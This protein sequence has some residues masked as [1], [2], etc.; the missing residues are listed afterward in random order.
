MQKLHLVGFTTDQNGLILSARR[1][2]RSGGYTLVLDDS[3]AQAVE[4]MRARQE[5]EAEAAGR[6]RSDRA[7]SRLPIGEIQTR[8]RRGRSLKD[9]AKDAGVEPEWVERFAAP[10]FAERAEV[11][12]RVQSLYYKRQRLGPSGLRVGDAVRRNLA[13][14]GVVMS[15]AEYNDAWKAVQRPDGRWMVTFGFQ[16]RGANRTLK[17]EVRPNGDIVASDQLTS[18]IAYVTPPK[19]STPRPRPVPASTEDA[20][21]KRAVVSTGF[22]PDPVVKAVSRP[23][24]ER[25]KAAAAMSKAAAKRAI[26]GERAANRKAREREQ[27]MLR[28]ERARAADA[29]RREREVAAKA[30]EAAAAARLVAAEQAEREKATAAI[31]AARQAERDAARRAARLKV[32]AESK[33][34]AAKK[35]AASKAGRANTAKAAA[36][37]RSERA[38]SRPAVAP[39]APRHAKPK[40]RPSADA[41]VDA[42]PP[43]RAAATTPAPER[44]PAPAPERR[45]APVPERRATPAPAPER[46]PAPARAATPAPAPRPA[47]RPAPRPRPTLAEAAAEVYG[48]EPRRAQFREG[49]A[50]QAT[51]ATPATSA[52][53]DNGVAPRRPPGARRTRPLRAT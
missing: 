48:N 49:A 38:S 16:H 4:E 3:L 41:R 52:N 53:P 28:L 35:T 51:Q 40:G 15:P 19:R 50:T 8:L 12:A 13:E 20:S 14:R 47:A 21:A 37:I 46:R 32:K 31:A 1:G 36:A 26:E 33:V 34:V 9:V 27:A 24:K 45:P 10:V 18:Q 11:V 39:G 22:R 42:P 29:I 17:F 7:E 25:E 6:G 23:G 44:R 2:A 30:R 5:A 43:R